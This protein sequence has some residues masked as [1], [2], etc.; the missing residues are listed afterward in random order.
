MKTNRS[1]GFRLTT[2]ATGVR[3]AVEG[4]DTGNLAIVCAESSGVGRIRL[5]AFRTMARRAQERAH[6]LNTRLESTQSSNPETKHLSAICLSAVSK[7]E[8]RYKPLMSSA[9]IR[10]KS[11]AIAYAGVVSRRPFP[12]PTIPPPYPVQFPSLAPA[13]LSLDPD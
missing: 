9:K 12:S 3:S 11:P 6:S 13:C 2:A 8:S 1:K 4:I 5:I 7:N 10:Q